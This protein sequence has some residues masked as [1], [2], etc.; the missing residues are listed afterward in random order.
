MEKREIKSRI[1]QFVIE[2]EK[3]LRFPRGLIGFESAREF[4]L[5]Q[6][7][8]NSPFL[9]LQNIENPKLG[10][11][12]A[13][14]YTFLANYSVVIGKS[15]EKIL[16]LQSVYDLTVLVTVTIPPGE[17]EKTT[18]NL[19]GPILI[20]TKAR[21]GLQVPQVELTGASRVVLADLQKANSEKQLVGRSGG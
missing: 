7:K 20:N 16:R 11:I 5:L 13:D 17:P 15:E 10:L 9:L 12:V 21:L 19:A 1:G 3:I 18:L 8:P 6:V 2:E 4:T 14:P